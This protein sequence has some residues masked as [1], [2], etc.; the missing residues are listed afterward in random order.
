MWLH[1]DFIFNRTKMGEEQKTGLNIIHGIIDNI[2][3]RKKKEYLAV[4]RGAV[5]ANELKVSLLDQ[6]V[7]HSMKNKS[8]DDLELRF[9]IYTIYIAV[10]VF[11]FFFFLTS[12]NCYN[13]ILI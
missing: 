13:V 12:R 11:L 7:E 8:M 1:P 9:E 10:R 5:D 3:V 2:I 4:E 6:L